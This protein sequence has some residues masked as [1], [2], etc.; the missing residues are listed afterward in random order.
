MRLGLI[1]ILLFTA[2]VLAL[3]ASSACIS[4]A[5]SSP[6]SSPSPMATPPPLPTT[7]GTVTATPS[8]RPSPIAQRSAKASSLPTARGTVAPT[9]SP[10]TSPTIRNTPT[11]TPSLTATAKPPFLS[12]ADGAVPHLVTHGNTQ[13]PWVSLTFDNGADAGASAEV[14]DILRDNHIHSTFFVTGKWAE[15]NPELVKRIVAEG[16]TIA[17]HS[18][19]HPD[20]RTIG[21]DQIVSQLSQTEEIVKR[22]AGVSTKPYF[23][24]PFGAYDN[25]VLRAVGHEGYM[26]IYWTIDGTDWRDDSTVDSVVHWVMKNVAPGAIIIHHSAPEKTAKALPQEIRQMHEKGLQIVNLPELLGD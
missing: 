17:N 19:S 14:L 3:L 11:A 12:N 23:R 5:S 8:S 15:A 16:H 6:L 10:R 1:R 21:D 7:K 25:R 22:I 26:P 13:K 20:F 4:V 24:P 2:I 18:Y 9:P